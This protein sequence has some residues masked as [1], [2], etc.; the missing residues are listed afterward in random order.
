MDVKQ[1]VQFLLELRNA[2]SP[3]MVFG[4]HHVQPDKGVPLGPDTERESGRDDP[5]ANGVEVWESEFDM[6]FQSGQIHVFC[7]LEEAIHQ[8]VAGLVQWSEE[9]KAQQYEITGHSQRFLNELWPRLE[10][11][12]LQS[13]L[14][15]HKVKAPIQKRK[16]HSRCDGVVLESGLP[17]Q[18]DYKR[19]GFR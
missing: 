15:H 1:G 14:G 17:V 2:L 11:D 19:I 5:L 12:V 13:V 4:H 7:D 9:R 6:L 16:L 8:A 3:Q 18:I 10:G